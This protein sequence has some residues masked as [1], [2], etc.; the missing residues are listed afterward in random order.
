[1]LGT[2]SEIELV[3]PRPMV[4]HG[5][6]SVPQVGSSTAFASAWATNTPLAT[7]PSMPSQ[8][9]STYRSSG[10][11][12]LLGGAQAPQPAAPLQFSTPLQVVK[13]VVMSQ[14]FFVPCM[15]AW[16]S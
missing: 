5:L 11:S 4:L 12:V 1:M 6:A 2:L 3:S 7:S 14:S 13:G 15:L 10:S 8:S 9:L 16:H